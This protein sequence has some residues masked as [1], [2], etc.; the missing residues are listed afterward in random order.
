MDILRTELNDKTAMYYK[1][2]IKTFL[3]TLITLCP[4]LGATAQTTKDISLSEDNPYTDHLSL[5]DD[6]KDMDLMVKFVFNESSN[7]LSVFLISYRDLFV[8]LTDTPYKQAISGRKIKPNKLP[9]VVNTEPGAT[10]KLTKDYEKTF[11]KPRKKHVFKKW[12]EYSGLLP[13]PTEYK[14]VNDFV[15]QDLT[16]MNNADAVTI[17]LHD[18][19]MLDLQ[20]NTNPLKKKYDVVWGKDLDVTYHIYIDRNPCFSKEEDIQTARKSLESIAAGYKNLADRFGSGIVNDGE[21]LAN[22]REMKKLLVAQYPI[23]TER[24]NCPYLQSTWDAYNEYVDSINNLR[25]RIR[26]A[27][28]YKGSGNGSIKVNVPKDGVNA[29]YILTQARRIDNA[30]SRWLVSKDMTERSD[31][32]KQCLEII[33]VV[34]STVAQKGLVNESQKNAMGIFNQAVKYYYTICK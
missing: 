25:C 30:V 24:S 33:N 6:S 5:K 16:V 10:Y 17:T 1:H 19:M 18:V 23:K 34:K 4:I 26:S 20:P 9:F 3:L 15:Q 32:K 13:I 29:G 27:V 8:F 2:H 7:T 31:L 12:F 21:S 22:F 11:A 28:S 14:M